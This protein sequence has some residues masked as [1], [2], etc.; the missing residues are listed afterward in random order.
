MEKLINFLKYELPQYEKKLGAFSVLFSNICC[1]VLSFIGGMVIVRFLSKSEYGEYTYIVNC[2]GVLT[3]LSD[4][5]ANVAMMQFC[6]QNYDKRQ[7]FNAYFTYGYKKGILF[8]GVS[9]VLLFLSP[10]FY[11]FK[12][13][14]AASL[15]R[16]LCVWPLITANNTFISSNLRV[17]LKNKRYGI[18]NFATTAIN[19][20]IIL[21]MA[22]IGGL[23]GAVYSNYIIALCTLLLGILLSKGTLQYDWKADILTKSEKKDFL[24]LSFASQLNNS[25]DSGLMLL[26]VFLIGLFI[27]ENEVISSYKVAST[28]PTALAFIPNSLM[29]CVIPHFARHCGNVLWVKSAYQKLVSFSMCFNSILVLGGCLTAPWIIPWIFGTQYSDSVLCFQILM[30]GYFF[31][32]SFRTPTANVLYTQRRIKDNLMITILSGTSNCILDVCFILTMGSI[33]AALATT[34]VHILNSFISLYLIRR[35]FKKQEMIA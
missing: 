16:N 6:S 7:Y 20:L 10:Y 12:S 1:K 9:C 25:I 28:I 11:P 3:L 21:P 34:T 31:S 14:V 13:E 19:Y 22:A 8:S 24:K 26:D 35:Y 33:G 5:G 29:I 27:G 2:I 4:L 15:T 30:I 18:L 23:K 17:K 32:A